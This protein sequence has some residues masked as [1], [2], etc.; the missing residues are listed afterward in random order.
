MSDATRRGLEEAETGDES[1][2]P[3]VIEEE[4]KRPEDAEATEQ[5]EADGPKGR[6]VAR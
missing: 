3:L 1:G 6:G 2:A 5:V 4:Q